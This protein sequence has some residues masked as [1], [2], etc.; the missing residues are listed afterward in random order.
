[1]A[2]ISMN[3]SSGCL[4]MKTD[5]MVIL[6]FYSPY[7]IAAGNVGANYSIAATSL[8][9]TIDRLKITLTFAPAFGANLTTYADLANFSFASYYAN[10]PTNT[11]Q[12]ASPVYTAF[13]N[14]IYQGVKLT[15]S[16]MESDGATVSP[17]LTYS[18]VLYRVVTGDTVQAEGFAIGADLSSTVAIVNATN[19]SVHLFAVDQASA[20]SAPRASS[21]SIAAGYS[22]NYR[23]DAASAS[24]AKQQR[25][26]LRH[27]GFV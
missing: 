14:G 13:A 1:M 18:D 5:V 9:F 11:Y 20:N 6:P 26:I 7:D 22:G 23:W 4:R 21:V 25:H 12:A 3:L 8:T 17:S 2:V 19:G 16:G 10:D 27:G 24:S 15:I